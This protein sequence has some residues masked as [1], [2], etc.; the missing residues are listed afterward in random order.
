[1]DHRKLE[2]AVEWLRTVVQYA[3]RD[4]ANCDLANTGEGAYLLT[5]EKPEGTKDFSL[6]GEQL[7]A[8]ADKDDPVR[9]RVY[10]ALFDLARR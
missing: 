3:S 8:I 6:T 5:F 10:S 9:T 1:V 7:E 2:I 4:S